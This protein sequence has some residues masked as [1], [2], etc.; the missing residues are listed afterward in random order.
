MIYALNTKN[1]EHEAVIQ[2]IKEQH[3]DRVQQLYS[4]TRTKVEFYK[5]SQKQV[6][7]KRHKTH[8]PYDLCDI[9]VIKPITHMTCV[10]KAQFKDIN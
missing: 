7:Y 3:E 8:H 9:N 5:V 1:D 6:S 2:T 10:T 4:E